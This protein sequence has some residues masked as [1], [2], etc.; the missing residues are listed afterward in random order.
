MIHSP[1]IPPYTLADSYSAED[2][3]EIATAIDNDRDTLIS[4]YQ[5]FL[6]DNTTEDIITMLE[7]ETY[8][9]PSDMLEKR[10]ATELIKHQSN[11]KW[12]VTNLK[13]NNKMEKSFFEKLGNTL[14]AIAKRLSPEI[15]ALKLSATDG[16]EIEFEN[17]T[18]EVN[19]RVISD[20]PNGTYEI[21]YSEKIYMVTITDKVVTEMVEKTIEDDEMAQLRKENE[22]LKAKLQ[23]T[24]NKF[25]ELN[26]KAEMLSQA[27]AKLPIKETTNNAP[28]VTE[29]KVMATLKARKEQL[30]NK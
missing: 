20:T 5:R 12:G 24:E 26:T 27:V 29:N 2:L 9:S 7:A 30:N 16:T 23:A 21:T 3:R 18:I 19:S 28:I 13:T 8:L 4:I 17:D 14:D 11:N 15:K 10:F 1:Y 22:E 6:T 25:E